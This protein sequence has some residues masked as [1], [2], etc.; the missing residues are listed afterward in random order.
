MFQ[1]NLLLVLLY[2]VIFIIFSSELTALSFEGVKKALLDTEQVLKAIYEFVSNLVS[3]FST[4]LGWMGFRAFA[5][6]MGI[7]FCYRFIDGFFPAARVINILIGLFI[8]TMLWMMWNDVYYE[9]YEL[10]VIFSTYLFLFSHIAVLFLLQKIILLAVNKLR[11]IFLKWR[12]KEV[13]ILEFYDMIDN[14][15]LVIKENLKAGKKSQAVKKLKELQLKIEYA[16][17]NTENEQENI[18]ETIS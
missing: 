1:R 12:N 13:N 16:G 2:S 4:L 7:Y 18:N 10:D 9:S 14:Y 15:S 5:S 3:F 6:A 8:F 17:S 11:F